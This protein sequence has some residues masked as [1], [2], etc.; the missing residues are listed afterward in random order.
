MKPLIRGIFLMTLIASNAVTASEPSHEI[1][2]IESA[3]KAVALLADQQQFETLETL[4][5]DEILVDYTSLNGGDTEVKSPQALITEWAGV[6][7]GFDQ[8]HHDISNI[9]V[10]VSG[11]T[12]T[13][14]ANVTADH[15]LDKQF[16]QVKGQY[17]YQFLR[18]DKKW[19]ITAMTFVLESE[20][21]SRNIFG[22]A[23]ENAQ[24]NPSGYLKRQQTISAVKTFLE[25]LET[26]DANSLPKYG[27]RTP[28]RTCH[29]HQ[30]VI[31]SEWPVKQ[32][33]LSFTPLSPKS[34]AMQISPRRCFYPH[35][36]PETVFVEFNGDVDVIP[37]G[38]RYQQTYGGLFHVVDGKIKLFREYYD[39]APYAW[40]FGLS[41]N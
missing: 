15:Y 30:T 4:F 40:A 25:S 7:P 12:A 36:D 21:G 18:A 11:K 29:I 27:L 1:A 13:A 39:P 8:T 37:T 17:R 26:K 41:D 35:I 23:I 19:Y 16:W 33:L 28:F 22:P 6:L 2:A 5:A 10:E 38:R 24:L 31:R 20:Q 9:T 3:V 34:V 14:S 32:R